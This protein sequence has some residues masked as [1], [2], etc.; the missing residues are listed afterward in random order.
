MTPLEIIEVRE[1]VT[2][3]MRDLVFE[4]YLKAGFKPYVPEKKIM[5]RNKTEGRYQGA[6]TRVSKMWG[7]Y[8]VNKTGT[9]RG[10]RHIRS[11]VIPSEPICDYFKDAK[12]V[13]VGATMNVLSYRYELARSA[14]VGSLVKDFAQQILDQT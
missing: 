12:A 9:K 2:K 3:A 8:R 10:K 5:S 4:N 1:R 7:D 6:V 14:Q 13:S 11:T